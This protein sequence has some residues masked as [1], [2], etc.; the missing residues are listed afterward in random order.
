MSTKPIERG[1][2]QLPNAPNETISTLRWN[3]VMGNSPILLATSW[4]GFISTYHFNLQS[5]MQVPQCQQ[6]L[7]VQLSD[8]PIVDARWSPLNPAQFFMCTKNEIDIVDC[9]TNQKMQLGQ[10]DGHCTG[11]AI[12][13]TIGVIA[14]TG[15][16]GTVKMWD[17]KSNQCVQS[18]PLGAPLA[19]IDAH[20]D[21]MCCASPGKLHW[22]MCSQRQ[23]V[24]ETS[25]LAEKPF[26]VPTTSLCVA[27]V[28]NPTNG[29]PSEFT[30]CC[31]GRAD[32]RCQIWY[33]DE[34]RKYVDQTRYKGAQNFT[35]IAATTNRWKN[36]GGL[37]Q[38]NSVCSNKRGNIVAAVGDG[39][40]RCWDILKKALG[41]PDS[42]FEEP[43][44]GSN[45]MTRL[46]P[47]TTVGYTSID[48]VGLYAY[49]SGYDW[50][51]G[52]NPQNF[53]V[54]M[55]AIYVKMFEEV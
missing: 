18:I 19:Y 23:V 51:R 24:A 15:A 53:N 33:R 21:D 30:F 36:I 50:S 49:A 45:S 6:G 12:C 20:N 25:T 42:I 55:P 32:G 13:M 10:H 4:N 37:S 2:T 34:P 26:Q 41:S 5:S 1:V 44:Q 28:P 48:S 39:S 8:A 35:F 46:Q 43:T 7:N 29:N 3:T 22:I 16:D 11:C 14:T 47:I 38:V 17:P 52:A 54:Q 40:L 27:S 31:A 9:R